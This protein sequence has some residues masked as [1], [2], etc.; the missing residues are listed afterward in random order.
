M[1]LKNEPKI[2]SPEYEIHIRGESG[3]WYRWTR[4]GAA[5]VEFY[6]SPDSNNK[7][8]NRDDVSE[9]KVVEIKKDVTRHF[10]R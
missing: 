4:V 2:T 8:E 9:Y 5:E 6:T 10:I 3:I 7:L 1:K